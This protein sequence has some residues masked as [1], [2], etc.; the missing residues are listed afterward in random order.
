MRSK[1][2]YGGGRGGFRSNNGGGRGGNQN[3]AYNNNNA[4]PGT[5]DRSNPFAAH[6]DPSFVAPL[7]TGGWAPPTGG[8]GYHRGP[9]P[10]P[11]GGNYGY[12]NLSPGSYNNYGYHGQ[13]QANPY[14]PGQNQ[15]GYPAPVADFNSRGYNN[16]SR[17]G[18]SNAGDYRG[19]NNNSRDGYH[20]QN[21]NG[22]GY[23]RGGGYD[24]Y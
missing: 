24:R 21:R 5:N 12:Q 15:Y 10:P 20:S 17:G 4:R 2:R 19:Y 16:Q 18:G 13:T 11:R 1:S 3:G 23:R 6:L 7:Q 9:P 14:A 8:A 22:N